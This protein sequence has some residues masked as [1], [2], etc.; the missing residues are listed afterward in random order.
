MDALKQ[1]LQQRS[2]DS[3]SLEVSRE[4]KRSRKAHGTKT[5]ESD[6]GNNFEGDIEAAHEQQS[7]NHSNSYDYTGDFSSHEEADPKYHHHNVSDNKMERGRGNEYEEKTSKA[8]NVENGG[9]ANAKSVSNDILEDLEQPDIKAEEQETREE[10][11]S[12]TRLAASELE[13]TLN[14]IKQAT[15]TLLSEIDV[16][17]Q[18]AEGVTIDYLRCRASQKEEAHRLKEIE[19]D[20]AGATE[21]FLRQAQ[22]SFF[23]G[24][25]SANGMDCV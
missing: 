13:S 6:G 15:K 17:L 7:N 24:M 5:T 14:K 23:D 25:G 1:R 10:R 8:F 4:S 21:S 12:S 18:T 20:V 9:Q 22:Q 19:P 16:Y 11:V 3:S 2:K